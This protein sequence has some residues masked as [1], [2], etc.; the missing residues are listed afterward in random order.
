MNI[1]APG[2]N[3]KNMTHRAESR[4]V[5]NVPGTAAAGTFGKAGKRINIY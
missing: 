1:F 2:K 5:G 3:F 4:H